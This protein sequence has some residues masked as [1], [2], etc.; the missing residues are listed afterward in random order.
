MTAQVERQLPLSIP[1]VLLYEGHEEG[2]HCT[3]EAAH[4]HATISTTAATEETG[5][6]QCHP[7]TE[8]K[9][10]GKLAIYEPR[11]LET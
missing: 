8:G 6:S 4:S 5:H 3:A 9:A 2:A 1:A 7:V 11:T 10:T